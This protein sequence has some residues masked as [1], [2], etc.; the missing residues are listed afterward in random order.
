[1]NM[2][3]C[4]FW[5]A[6]LCVVSVVGSSS[7]Q[8]LDIGNFD[9]IVASDDRVWLVEFGSKFCESCKAFSPVFESLSKNKALRFGACYVDERPG[10][11]LAK[12]FEVLEVSLPALVLF[13]GPGVEHTVIPIADPSATSAIKQDIK[14]AL[15]S[16]SKRDG[17]YWKLSAEL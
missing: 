2:G 4:M 8:E 7:I 14:N 12:K 13:H 6:A 17:L 9:N 5:L 10:L 3:G 15:A 1:M 16:L 11:D